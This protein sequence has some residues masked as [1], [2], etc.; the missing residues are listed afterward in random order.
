MASIFSKIIAG[1]IPCHRIAENDEFLA[2]LDISPLAEGHTLVIP[3][4]EV[5]YFFDL[6][7]ELLARINLFARDVAQKIEASIPC[8][9]VGVAVIGLEVPHAHMHLIPLQNVSDINFER[10]KLSFTPEELAATAERIKT[11]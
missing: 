4:N 5:D 7:A 8:K 9:R 6:D 2:F 1:D 10:P 3:K 11:A